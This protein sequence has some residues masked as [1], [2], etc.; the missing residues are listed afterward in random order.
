MVVVL[1]A[2]F[3]TVLLVIGGAVGYLVVTAADGDPAPLV[4]VGPVEL[5]EPLTFALVE[6]VSD[7]PCSAPAVTV[8]GASS[9][10]TFG[11]DRLTVRRLEKVGTLAPDPATGRTGWSVSVTLAP[12]DRSGLAALTGRAAQASADGLPSGRMGMLVGGTLLSEPPQVM[13]A[14]PGGAMEI[15]GGAAGSGTRSEAELLTRRLTGR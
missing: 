7:P 6:Q 1:F 9:C 11:A 15:Y 3:L 12:A 5:R 13:S 2:A 4:S 10:Y 14:I 8:A